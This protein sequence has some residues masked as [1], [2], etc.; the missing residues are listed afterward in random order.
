M[1]PDNR[2]SG[3]AYLT[4]YTGPLDLYF[5]GSD[6]ILFFNGPAI[7]IRRPESF[8]PR[9]LS[10]KRRIPVPRIFIAD[11]LKNKIEYKPLKYRAND[12]VQCVR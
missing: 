1:F 10:T 9:I 8:I 4:H 12:R 6:S 3:R 7:N 11:P 5:K 2:V